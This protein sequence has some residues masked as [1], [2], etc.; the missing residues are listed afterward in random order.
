MKVTL[1]G[2]G[3]GSAKT[4]TP[5]AYGA[6]C[7][8]QFIAGSRRLIDALPAP[9][10]ARTAA[11][12]KPEAL[13]A[14]LQGAQCEEACV[15]FSGDTGFYSGARGLVPLLRGCE[16]H[17]LPGISSMQAL[18]AALQR[19]WQGWRLVSAHGVACDPVTE[20]VHG[21][22]TLFLTGGTLGPASLCRAL[23]EAGLGELSVTVGEN[24]SYPNECITAGTAATFAAREFAP[25][26]VLLAEPA[27]CMPRRTPGWPDA[28]FLRAKAIPMTKQEVRAAALAKLAVAPGDI[29]WDIGAGTGSVSVELAAVCRGAW[30]VER[31]A[32]ACALLRQNRAK[33]H[34][35]PLRI[36]EGNAPEVLHTLPKPD[37][38]FVGG[39]GGRLPEILQA[40]YD[41]NSAARVCVPAIALETVQTA[42]TA[43]E[44]LGYSVEI[45]QISVSRTKAAG[46]LHMLL[47]HNPVFLLTGTKPCAG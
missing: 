4:L 33:F 11:A 17:V 35:Y 40:V 22:P 46:G 12:T 14:L 23:E 39:S 34:A 44:N 1:I 42:F 30:A 43:L 28:D 29:C 36:V 16:V 13:A 19:P 20:V 32:E 24:L 38:V 21:A 3:C 9:C 26:S 27:P 15:I 18:A 47:A 45:A 25:L 5:E 7:K 6:L 41:A 10:T 31:K 37:A 2:M 8:A